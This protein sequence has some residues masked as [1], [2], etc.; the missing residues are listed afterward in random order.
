M[1]IGNSDVTRAQ[2]FGGRRLPLNQVDVRFLH[3]SP[4]TRHSNPGHP[5]PPV[6]LPIASAL[7]RL[8]LSG[9]GSPCRHAG[10]KAK[11]AQHHPNRPRPALRPLPDP[12]PRAM[13]CIQ[14]D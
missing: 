5:Q 10:A 12:N 1:E 9:A 14:R 7:G 8:L 3:A 4:R 11:P 13:S 2:A 6:P